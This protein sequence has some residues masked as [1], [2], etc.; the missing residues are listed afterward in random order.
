MNRQKKEG[1][2]N[3]SFV[4]YAHAAGASRDGAGE[5][6]PRSHSTPK[7]DEPLKLFVGQVPRTMEEDALRTF[8]EE[9]GQVEDVVIIRDRFS[10]AHRGMLQTPE[11][12]TF[13]DVHLLRSKRDA[14]PKRLSPSFTTK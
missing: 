4:S 12:V 1:S 2:E 11:H 6:A 3:G 9:F 7:R 13:Q 10:A 5:S 14:S 8:M